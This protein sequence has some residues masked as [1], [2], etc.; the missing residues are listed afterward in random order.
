MEY[1]SFLTFILIDS[2]RSQLKFSTLRYLSGKGSFS[3]VVRR[4]V[5]R[6]VLFSDWQFCNCFR[7]LNRTVFRFIVLGQSWTLHS[8]SIRC[9]PSVPTAILLYKINSVSSS[10]TMCKKTIT[11]K[12]A[13]RFG[14]NRLPWHGTV[15]IRREPLTLDM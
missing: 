7:N 3:F 9:S 1:Q 6:C 4:L 14:G 12:Y 2:Y 13:Q 15:I 5:W 10:I 11:K 8:P